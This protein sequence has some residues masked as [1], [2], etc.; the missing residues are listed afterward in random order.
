MAKIALLIGVSEYAEGL[1]SLPAAVKDVAAMRSILSDPEI[2]GFDRVVPLENPDL[3]TMQE[4]IA[5]LFSECGE[6]D[7]LLLYFSGHGI[8]DEFGK[9]YFSNRSSRKLADGRLNKGTAVPA[10]FVH[11]QMENCES[12][13]M[14]VILDCC[15]SGAFGAN[16]A[17]DE[18]TIDFSRQLGGEGRIVLTSSSAIEYSFERSGEELAVYTRYL[19]EGLRTGA[20]DLDED[21]LI[22]ANELHEFV[23]TKLTRAMPS[24]HPERY[25]VRDGEKIVLARAFVDVAQK[26]RKLVE[27]YCAEGEIRPAGRRMLDRR[28]QGFGLDA[29]VARQIEDEVLQPYREHRA[30]LAEYEEVLRECKFP[31]DERDRRE[32]KELQQELGLTDES[33]L[34]IERRIVPDAKDV[35][36]PASVEPKPT[37]KEPLKPS[38]PV[39]SF[40]VIT[41]ND[42]GQEIDRRQSQANYRREELAKGVFLDM[43]WIPGGTFW[44][45]AAEGELEA[46]DIEKPR[47]QVTIEPFFM[48]KYAV[49]QAQWKAIA[50]FPKINRAL[51]LDP[52]KF[53]GN[54]RPVERI[55]WEDAIEFCERLTRKTGERY[56]LPSEA[57]WEYACRAG[58]TTP[59]HFGETITF[60]LVNYNG[61]NTYAYA[62]KGKYRKT[63]IDVGSFPPNAFG[64]YEM[65]GNV[66]EWCADPWH[67][68]YTNAPVD[69][70]VWEVE[71]DR[72][73][74]RRVLRGGSWFNSPRYCRSAARLFNAAGIRLNL[75]GFRVVCSAP[76]TL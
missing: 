57:E 30:N 71:S 42:R 76:R 40:E 50:Q 46:E 47:H 13:R 38:L 55:F 19:V 39:F 15:N 4:E 36:V 16:V 11:D 72:E 44:M 37:I 2:G 49:T 35:E 24:M 25:V 28:A 22:S 68:S 59:F 23:R 12:R 51:E 1:K 18:G 5:T 67:D 73:N 29:A 34:E 20:A 62:A 27:Q 10:S 31:L 14:V 9:F 48:G 52:S 21:G 17:R 43:V 6:E 33:V 60:D 70:R 26:Y 54:N 65:H 58:T 69:G 56:R 66:W 61:N 32:L 53:K 45:G 74:N 75:N 8:T 7:L 64:L 63:T 3:Q 41:V